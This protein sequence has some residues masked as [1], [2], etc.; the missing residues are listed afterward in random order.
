MSSVPANDDVGLEAVVAA[1]TFGHMA[2]LETMGDQ[3]L[4]EYIANIDEDIKALKG[5]DEHPESLREEI[6]GLLLVFSG[7]AND[8]L[9]ARAS[10]STAQEPE[11]S[12]AA[13]ADAPTEN[14]RLVVPRR[15]PRAMLRVIRYL[16]FGKMILDAL[17]DG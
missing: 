17:L 3:Q 4:Q 13:Q 11:E 1:V 10:Q 6:T 15:F 7:I 8:K 12:A 2:L 14:T 5:D 16:P 9:Y